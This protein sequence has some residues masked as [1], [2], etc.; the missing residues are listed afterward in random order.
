LFDNKKAVQ[1]VYGDNLIQTNDLV[2]ELIYQILQKNPLAVD[3]IVKELESG[4][5]SEELSKY[6][7]YNWPDPLPANATEEQ[8]DARRK[9]GIYE[10]LEGSIGKRKI[11]LEIAQKFVNEHPG[12]IFYCFS[13]S[14][15]GIIDAY[16]ESGVAFEH[17]PALCISHH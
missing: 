3:D 11:S 8:F 15:S 4:Y 5:F 9:E 2:D 10:D 16:L 12:L 6:D 1:Q 7:T 14:D 17:V 13:F